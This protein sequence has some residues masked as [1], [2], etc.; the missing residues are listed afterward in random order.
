MSFTYFSN[1]PTLNEGSS[2]QDM[3]ESDMETDS[4]TTGNTLHFQGTSRPDRI[5]DSV[6]DK[7]A[8]FSNLED[9][10]GPAFAIVNPNNVMPLHHP[11]EV[12]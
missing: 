1:D 8:P 3:I 11:L 7:Y 6:S 12:S 10:K 9:F 2:L 4:V 5:P